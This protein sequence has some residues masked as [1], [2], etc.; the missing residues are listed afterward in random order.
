MSKVDIDRCVS[1]AVDESKRGYSKQ[2]S[3]S[4]WTFVF[5]NKKL[6][7]YGRNVA[8]QEFLMKRYGY[9]RKCGGLHSEVVALRKAYGL[10]DRRK[11]WEIVNISLN[12]THTLRI[13]A[14]CPIC[15]SFISACGCTT[16]YFSIT[17]GFAKTIL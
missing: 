15:R 1:I 7:S 13:S 5:Q 11:P 10:M 3:Y 9:N 16:Y 4:H 2:F 12:A 14:P 8:K 17:D 6:L